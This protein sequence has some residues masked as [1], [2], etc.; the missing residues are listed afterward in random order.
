MLE[1]VGPLVPTEL[2]ASSPG[3]PRLASHFLVAVTLRPLWGPL[4][5]GSCLAQGDQIAM[6]L[7]RIFSPKVSWGLYFLEEV[8]VF[9]LKTFFLCFVFKMY[10]KNHV[11]VGE[12]RV[13]LK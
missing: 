11:C 10:I 2:A 12:K 13:F 1:Q 9:F 4:S 8:E 6:E 7:P 5:S 3:L